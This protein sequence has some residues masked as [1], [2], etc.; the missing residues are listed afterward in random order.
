MPL[1]KIRDLPEKKIC[2][3]P[4]HEFPN[5]MVL[6]PGI[7]EHTCPGCGKATVVRVDNSYKSIVPRREDYYD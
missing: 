7:W 6:E 1:K 3:D 4:E 2:R 5:M